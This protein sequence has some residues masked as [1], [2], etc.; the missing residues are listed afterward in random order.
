MPYDFLSE[1]WL[2]EAR[3]IRAEYKSLAAPVTNPVRINLVVTEVPD[4]GSIDA[5]L[6]TSG[7]ELD[8]EHGHLE[9]ADLT[10]TLDYET[11]KA[12]F[13]EGNSQ[14]AMSGF[15]AG[16]IRVDGDMSKL[17]AMQGAVAFGETEELA[18]RIRAI[19]S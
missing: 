6:D 13:A 12:L 11:A 15:M 19:T 7:G 8:I 16:K 4:S 1:Q 17:L 18:Q 14:A 5:H 9:G 2:S 3:K 10:V